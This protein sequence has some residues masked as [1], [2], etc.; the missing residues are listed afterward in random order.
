LPNLLSRLKDSLQFHS[1][2]H[3]NRPFFEATMAAAALVASADGSVSFSERYSLDQLREHL[4]R[5]RVFD[6]HEAVDLFNSYVEAI[7]EDQDEGREKA[8]AAVAQMAG[9]PED[10][11]LTVRISAAIS[12]AD[13][14]FN[15]IERDQIRA[16]CEVLGLTLEDCEI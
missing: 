2:R 11:K 6:P 4:D 10:A 1:E 7:S 13:G 15:P 12:R 16:I 9:T 8:L 14:D 3:R 5:L